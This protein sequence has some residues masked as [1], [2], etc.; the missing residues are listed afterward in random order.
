MFTKQKPSTK[1]IGRRFEAYT[2]FWLKSRNYKILKRNFVAGNK[3]IDIIA[4][5][6]STI[7]FVEVKSELINTENEGKETPPEKITPRK[8]QNIISAAKAYINELRQNSIDPEE[9]HFR[10]DGVGILFD[11]EYNMKEFKY[12]ENLYEVDQDALF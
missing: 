3:E 10:F 4:M 11:T 12:Y 6:G 2:A 8:M 9:F 1:W 7:C 5:K